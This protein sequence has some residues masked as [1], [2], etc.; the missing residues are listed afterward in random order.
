MQTASP[1]SIP[2]PAH[3]ACRPLQPVH[4]GLP[5]WQVKRVTDYIDANLGATLR[6]ASL[7]ATLGLSVSHFTR[8]FKHSVGVPPRV[9][10]IRRRL[11]AA[12]A[13]MVNSTT[14]LTTIA[15]AH[16]FCDQSHFTR[17]FHETIGLSPH[18]WRCLHTRSAA[19]DP[20]AS[21]QKRPLELAI[22][23]TA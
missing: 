11:A 8:A 16:G 22:V 18:V 3:G 10:V 12:C 2:I 15:H 17:T 6:T 7:A 4:G 5:R 20:Y 13:E 19:A 9:Y 1:I 23:E 21:E 14:P